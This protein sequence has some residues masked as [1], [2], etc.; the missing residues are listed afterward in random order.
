[1]SAT[2]VLGLRDLSFYRRRGVTVLAVVRRILL[3]GP[4]EL[5]VKFTRRTG[6]FRLLP[7]PPMCFGPTLR[8][9]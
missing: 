6:R 2:A 8:D 5:H 1:M 9:E 4:S 3:R 7:L